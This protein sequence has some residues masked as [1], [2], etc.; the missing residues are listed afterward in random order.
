MTLWQQYAFSWLSASTI[1][2]IQYRKF[3]DNVLRGLQVVQSS[4]KSLNKWRFDSKSIPW[5]WIGLIHTAHCSGKANNV[6]QFSI[7][8]SILLL[9][10]VL[11]KVRIVACFLRKLN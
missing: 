4:S 8:L 9:I 5:S 3:N 6:N 2:F 1:Y 11:V 7:K 10:K